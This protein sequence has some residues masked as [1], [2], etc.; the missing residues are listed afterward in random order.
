MSEPLASLFELFV[1]E[2]TYLKAVSRKTVTWYWTAWKSFQASHACPGEA[3]ITKA[4]LQAFVVSL[5][6]RGVKPRSV[7]TYLQCLQ[8]LRQVDA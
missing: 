3:V 5:R 6:G 2:R 4:G 8:R 7:N 1:K